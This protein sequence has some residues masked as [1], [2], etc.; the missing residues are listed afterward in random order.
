MGSYELLQVFR[1]KRR[2]RLFLINLNLH[3]GQDS[4]PRH[5][6]AIRG[7]LTGPTSTLITASNQP[8]IL[9]F[10][11]SLASKITSISTLNSFSGDDLDARKQEVGV[12]QKHGQ[13]AGG[14]GKA[15]SVDNLSDQGVILSAAKSTICLQSLPST[16]L[17]CLF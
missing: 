5:M 16:C 7:S 10:E 4:Q 8:I 17:S 11:L 9:P 1:V 6:V 14:E 3:E 13:T 12:G 15:V 2:C